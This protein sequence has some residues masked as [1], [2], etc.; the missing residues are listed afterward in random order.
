MLKNTFQHIPGIGNKSEADIWDS[1]ILCWDDYTKGASNRKPAKKT[2]KICRYIA[3]SQKHLNYNET[4]NY[5]SKLLPSK[6]HWRFFPEFI[7]SAVYLDIETDGLD[8]FNGKITT[9]A[10]YDGQNI[11]HYTNGF[12]LND[13][14]KDILKYKLIITYN[15]KSFDIP[16][17]EQF[18]GIEITQAHID[19]RYILASLGFKG[20]L[21]GCEKA[22]GIDRKELAGVDGYLAVLLWDDYIKNKNEKALETLLAYNIEDVLNLDFLMV[23]AYNMKLKETPFNHLQLKPRPVPEGPFRTDTATV[24]RIMNSSQYR[25]HSW[26]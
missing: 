10:L 13:F 15:G 8:S 5:F 12:N 6:L 7:D 22:L 25:S 9:I 17:I 21:K 18:F 1:G 16:F 2:D 4:P 24:K 14:K 26:Y 19:L 11:Y 20:G 3:E 23:T